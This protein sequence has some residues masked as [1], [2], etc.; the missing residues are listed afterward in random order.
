M[1]YQ[2]IKGKWYLAGLAVCVLLFGVSLSQ[3]I[4]HYVGAQ[5]A[6]EEFTE[7]AQIVE[8]TEDTPE[9]EPAGEEQEVISPLE[10]YAELF[11]MNN[12]KPKGGVNSPNVVLSAI[13]TPR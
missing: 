7:L 11:A 8:Q 5:K 2:K 3:V 10:R 12:D 6:E 13:I 9:E 1:K 4:S